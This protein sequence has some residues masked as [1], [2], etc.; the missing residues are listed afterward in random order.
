MGINIL[1]VDDDTRMRGAL[2]FILNMERSCLVEEAQTGK[3]ALEKLKDFN[4]D[5]ILMDVTMQG[6]D[7]I[8]TYKKLK[9]N[10]ETRA[11]P[12]LFL[13]AIPFKDI[14]RQIAITPDEYL[15]KPYDVEE[16]FA[17]IKTITER[18]KEV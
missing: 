14:T 6:M 10:P 13:S 18:S 2:K 16:L 11:I 4:P 15:E 17:R 3:E 9:E 8:E 7:G 12:V 5:I 1:L